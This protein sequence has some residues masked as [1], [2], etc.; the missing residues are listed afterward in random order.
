[1]LGVHA[2]LKPVLISEYN[3]TFELIVVEIVIASKEIRVITG[4]GPQENWDNSE[5]TPFYNALEDEIVAS[6]L[7]GRS[8]IIAMDANAKLG[9]DLVP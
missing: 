3:E 7:Q 4:Y 9:P 2:A 8:I 1:M 5:K 6:E